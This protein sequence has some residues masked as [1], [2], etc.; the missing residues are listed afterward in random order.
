MPPTE[1]DLAGF[2]AMGQKFAEYAPHFTGPISAEESIRLQ[3][4]VIDRAT[5]KEFGGQFVSQFGNK[6]WL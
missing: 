2:Q 4:E 1:E 6:Q 3:M 5:V